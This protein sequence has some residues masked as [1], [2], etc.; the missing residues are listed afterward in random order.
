LR[1]PSRS[2]GNPSMNRA[3]MAAS[4]VDH[5]PMMV[6]LGHLRSDRQRPIIE[7]AADF[8]ASWSS[9]GR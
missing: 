4:R 2:H 1:A 6:F 7:S 3:L 5:V 8:D 9:T